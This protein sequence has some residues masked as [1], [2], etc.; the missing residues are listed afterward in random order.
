M[1]SVYLAE[2]PSRRQTRAQIEP[3][4]P[5]APNA[6]VPPS[7]AAASSSSST[8]SSSAPTPYVKQ[9]INEH[10]GFSPEVYVDELIRMANEFVHAQLAWPLEDR[11]RDLLNQDRSRPEANLEAEQVSTSLPFPLPDTLLNAASFVP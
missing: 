11:V 3:A 6:P 7:Q 8:P 9:L 10:L 2:S 5:P 1:Y 4:Q